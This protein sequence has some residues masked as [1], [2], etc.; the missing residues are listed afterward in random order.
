MRALHCS[1]AQRKTDTRIANKEACQRGRK[2]SR[3][4]KNESVVVGNCLMK[5]TTLQKPAVP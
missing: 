5:V 3:G 1:D 2:K 4:I